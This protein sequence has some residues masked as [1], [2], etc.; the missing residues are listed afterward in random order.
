M[1][2]SVLFVCLLA[3]LAV[4]QRK[5]D[6]DS[7]SHW[8]PVKPSDF[9]ALKYTHVETRGVVRAVRREGDGDVHVWI[10]DPASV[11]VLGEC[12][13][14]GPRLDCDKLKRGESVI[15]RGISRYDRWHKFWEIHPV[16]ELEVIK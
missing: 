7:D 16:L 4:A 14:Q 9:A 6:E 13:P 10:C 1:K 12:I 15:L 2:I 8:E 5:P 3:I 11:C